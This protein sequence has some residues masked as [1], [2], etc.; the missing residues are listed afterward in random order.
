M[1]GITYNGKHS[2][3]LNIKIL[4][5]RVVEPPLKNKI[6]LTIPF[7]N[8]EYDF[9]N[10]Y[11]ATN[12]STRVLE[13]EFLLKAKDSILLEA[14]RMQ[15]ENWLL[16]RN[17]KTV[18]KDDNLKGYYYMAECTETEFEEK[19]NIGVLRATFNAYPFK[20]GEDFE[21][22]LKWDNFNF[23]LDVLQTTRFLVEGGKKEIALYNQGIKDVSPAIESTGEFTVTLRSSTHKIEKGVKDYPNIKLQRGLNYLQVEGNGTIA[24]LFRKELL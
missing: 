2:E 8:G 20:I 4:N 6:T 24:F 23:E 3:E 10:I 16:A 12:Y 17:E 13:Y 11:G 22:Y 14:K 5:T 1:Y 21:G 7:M 19:N 9:S 18:L 15:V